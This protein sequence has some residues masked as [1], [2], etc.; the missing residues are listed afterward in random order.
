MGSISGRLIWLLL[1]DLL[2][3]TSHSH[4]YM[5]GEYQEV[6]LEGGQDMSTKSAHIFKESSPRLDSRSDLVRRKRIG[7]DYVHKVIF[8]IRQRNIDELIRILHDVSDPLSSNYGQHLTSDEVA[9]LT[10]NPESRDTVVSYLHSNGASVTSE[11]LRGE[12]ITAQAPISVWEK[13]LNTEFF[14]FHQTHQNK[15]VSAV[16]RAEK[17]SIPIELHTHVESVFNTVEMPVVLFGS[18]PRRYSKAIPE[19]S[20]KWSTTDFEGYTTPTSIRT[21]YN[22]SGSVTGSAASTQAVFESNQQTYSPADLSYFQTYFNL[23]V[24]KVNTTIG[25]HMNDT[26]CV[27]NPGDCGESNLDLEYMMSTSQ[28]SPTTYWY[29]DNGFVDWLT[30]IANTPNPPLVLSI[31]YGSIEAYNGDSFKVAFSLQAIKLGTM[32]VTIVASSGDD[33]ANS[34]NA[35]GN[36]ANCGYTAIFPASNPYVTSVGA[37]MVRS[38]CHILHVVIHYRCCFLYCH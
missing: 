19:G 23:Q 28:K 27:I 2:I 4:R 9:D 22:M 11:T 12:Y 6:L 20:S 7:G 37:T 16:V 34:W 36:V 1:I 38:E 13:M 8:L 5:R 31:S 21:I 32:G 33:G 30:T 25:G 18:P 26:T 10:S 17:Y 35:R 15:R 14:T 3:S 24:N 29:T